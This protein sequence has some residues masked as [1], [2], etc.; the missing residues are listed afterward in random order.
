MLGKGDHQVTT[1]PGMRQ[2]KPCMVKA[3]L[4]EPQ[5]CG[6]TH[7]AVVGVVETAVQGLYGPVYPTYISSIPDTLSL[8]EQKNERGT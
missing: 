1:H 2:H 6:V 5:F 7:R 3:I 8:R 4:P